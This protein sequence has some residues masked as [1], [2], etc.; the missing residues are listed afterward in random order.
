M[1]NSVDPE[2]MANYEPTAH[3]EPSHLNLHCLQRYL[4][5]SADMKGLSMSDQ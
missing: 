2:E 4:Y 1:A 5:W 3:Y